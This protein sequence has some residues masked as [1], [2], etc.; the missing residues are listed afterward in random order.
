M[1]KLTI[2]MRLYG[3]IPQQKKIFT[4]LDRMM[5]VFDRSNFG[6]RKNLST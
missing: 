2:K 6:S 5:A 4:I 1:V 3:W